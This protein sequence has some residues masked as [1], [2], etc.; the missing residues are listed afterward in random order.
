MVELTQG[1]YGRYPH[2][3]KLIDI[4]NPQTQVHQI[5]SIK[6]VLDQRFRSVLLGTEPNLYEVVKS[7]FVL[8]SLFSPCCGHIEFTPESLTY[9]TQITSPTSFRRTQVSKSFSYLQFYD[10]CVST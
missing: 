10:D 2:S 5:P 1:R 9:L 6:R 4:P 7:S 3:L 8:E